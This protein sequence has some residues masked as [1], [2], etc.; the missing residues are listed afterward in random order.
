MNKQVKFMLKEAGVWK[1]F[2]IMLI[3]RSPFDILNSILSAN[4]IQ[5]FIRTIENKETGM[6]LKYFLLFFL[7]TVLLFAYNMTIWSTIAVNATVRLQ[8]NLRQIL[9]DKI[10]NMSYEELEGNFGA[11]FFT[12][13][14]NDVDKACSYLTSPLNYM[15]M[16]I[17]LVN[18]VISS[19]IMCFLDIELYI[20][21]ICFLFPFFFFNIFVVLKKVPVFKRKAQKSLIKY[22]EWIDIEQKDKETIV[23]QDAEDFVLDEIEKQSRMILKENMK[24][25]NR[26]SVCNMLYAFSGMLGYLML[27]WRGNG[28]IGTRLTDFAELT[29]MTQYRGR[30]VLSV[31][32]IYSCVNNMRSSLVGVER[33]NNVLI[34][35]K[36]NGKQPS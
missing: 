12:L 24:A 31:N 3:L 30:T 36:N 11:D 34:G 4:L 1:M 29:K 2:V 10:M 19:I 33:I 9:F 26:L 15:H 28:I 5:S 20:I 35:D 8:V 6:L 14:N 23:V 21:G 13:L 25:H 16:V 7:L 32:C 17:A 22:T 27:L 18:L